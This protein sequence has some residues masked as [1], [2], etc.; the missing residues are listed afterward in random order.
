MCFMPGKKNFIIRYTGYLFARETSSYHIPY[1]TTNTIAHDR[2][3]V[4]CSLFAYDTR[5]STKLALVEHV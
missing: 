5:M 1:I 2:G 3:V 4:L